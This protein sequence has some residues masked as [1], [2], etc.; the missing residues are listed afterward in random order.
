MKKTL[1]TVLTLAV[2]GGIVYWSIPSGEDASKNINQAKTGEAKQVDPT[3]L[4]GEED[5][6]A[7]SPANTKIGF[8]CSKTLAGKTLTMRGGWS[9]AFDSQLSGQVLVD[10]KKN[11]IVQIKL[12]IDVG[13]L[14][15]EHDQLT[16]ALL[17]QGFFQVDKHPQATFI[18]TKIEAISESSENDEA[19]S[20]ATHRIEGNFSLNGIEKSITFPA[21]ITLS[22][23]ELQLRSQ[24]SLRRDDFQVRFA[25]SAVLGLL[26][27]EDISERVAMNVKIRVVGRGQGAE[28][29]K[30]AATMLPTEDLSTLPPTYT[31]TIPATQIQFEMVLVPGDSDSQ[32]KPLYIGK[33]EVTWNEFM[34]WVDGRDLEDLNDL[35]ELRAMKRRPSS[36]YGSVDRGFGMDQRPALGMSRLSASLYCQWLSK[37]TGRK[38]RLPTEKEWERIYAAG[39]GSLEGPPT[40]DEAQSTAVY[41]KNSFND[42]ID[43]WAT[44]PMGAT[45]PNGLGVY[46]MAGNVC[47]WV[48]ETGD[49]RVARGGHY[50]SKLDKLGVGR[51]VEGPYW[52][53]DYPNEPKSI[54]WFINARWVGFRIVCEMPGK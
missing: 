53:R 40:A 49:E 18:S 43:D 44:K 9:E 14:W 47:E 16:E 22:E 7:L 19:E 3:D 52:N 17:T 15:S 54:W 10:R 11:K 5:A 28:G 13:S 33:H 4:S 12:Q 34:P 51:H 32:V 21:S 25:E 46:D 38:Y 29:S 23:S 45:V 24:F 50:R 37:Q 27:D 2:I 39:G 41:V 35:G 26:S 6:I 36:P 30:A 31:E 8:G 1:F 48:V 42:D 20:D